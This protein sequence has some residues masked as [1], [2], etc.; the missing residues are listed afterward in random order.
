MQKE[1]ESEKGLY[2]DKESFVTSAYLKKMKEMQEEEEKERRQAAME[3]IGHNPHSPLTFFISNL[4]QGK[5]TEGNSVNFV[6]KDPCNS[7][8]ENNN[9]YFLNSEI[10]INRVDISWNNKQKTKLHKFSFSM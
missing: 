8:S 6:C 10:A 1:R 4:I 3:G 9:S 5:I 2:D 7:S